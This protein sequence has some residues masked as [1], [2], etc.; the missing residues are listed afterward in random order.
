MPEKLAED[1]IKTWTN[2]SDIVIDPF[3]GSGTTAKMCLMN[4]RKFYGCEI[5]EEYCN[6]F[7]Q[8]LEQFETKVIENPLMMSFLD[9]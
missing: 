8:R 2:E 6:I 3:A 1:Q 9:T 4:H 5:S 7:I